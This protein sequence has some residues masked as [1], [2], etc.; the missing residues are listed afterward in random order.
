MQGAPASCRP[1]RGTGGG[2]STTP[3]STTRC[4]AGPRAATIPSADRPRPRRGTA[5]KHAAACGQAAQ[6]RYKRA[7]ERTGAACPGPAPVH[8]LTRADEVSASRLRVPDLTPS[9]RQESEVGNTTALLQPKDKRD[10]LSGNAL[11]ENPEPPRP[12]KITARFQVFPQTPI[13]ASPESND[14][15]RRTHDRGKRVAREPR[16]ARPTHTAPCLPDVEAL[17]APGQ[18][19]RRLRNSSIIPVIEELPPSTA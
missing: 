16:S 14:G 2:P 6:Q 11:G 19:G 5:H 13:P 18:P 3:T 1:R 15:P 12:R 4:A 10:D 8:P 9:T 17:Q 7:H